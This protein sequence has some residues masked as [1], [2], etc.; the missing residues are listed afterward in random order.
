MLQNH[1]NVKIFYLDCLFGILY[2]KSDM[3]KTKKYK[4]LNIK[5]LE[6][7]A[8]NLGVFGFYNFYLKSFRSYYKNRYPHVSNL[9]LEEKGNLNLNKL[10]NIY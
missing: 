3:L 7:L 8:K 10:A 1:E 6:K 2:A 5:K 9:K 4:N